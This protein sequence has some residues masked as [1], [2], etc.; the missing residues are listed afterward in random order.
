MNPPAAQRG[1]QLRLVETLRARGAVPARLLDAFKQVARHAFVEEA[2]WDQAYDDRAL[3]IGEKQTISQPSV[4]AT[5][6]M[7]LAPQP[8][9]RILEIGTGSG[10][11]TALL[12]HLVAQVYSIERLPGLARSAH[13]RLRAM[14]LSNVHVKTFDGTYGWR[15]R[16]PFQGIIVTAAAP[17]VPATL[18]EQLDE[19]G[20]LVLPVGEAEEQSLIRIVREGGN[21]RAED[22]GA[23]HFVPLIGRFGWAERELP[24]T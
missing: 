16:A 11:Q 10:Y 23:C 21:L 6:L 9:D 20:R 4:V 2:L 15:D 3:P 5:M 1:R 13:A 24:A 19:G 8:T 17:E 7:M 14:G 22:H 18:T 12:A